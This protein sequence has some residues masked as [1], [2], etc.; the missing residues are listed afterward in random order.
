MRVKILCVAG[1]RPNFM[2]IAPLMRAFAKNPRFEAKLVHTGQHYDA[3]L[4][5]V[6]FEDLAI[7]RPDIELAV[8]S[9]SHAV[10]TAEIMLRFEPILEQEQPH[11]VLVVGDVNSTVACAL[12]TSKFRLRA[13]F[14]SSLGLRHRPIMIHVEA[15]LRSFDDDM[16]EEINR[17]LTDAA[18]D[19]LFV[20]EP[21]GLANLAREGVP[22]KRV[23]FVGNVMIDSLLAAKERALRSTILESLGLQAG[24]YGLVTLHRPSNVDDPK[25][26]SELLG[27]LGELA[28]KL[29][30]VFPVHPRTS[31]RLK[32]H[33]TPLDEGRWKLLE[34]VG[35]FDFLKLM[36]CASLVLTD[37][38]GIQ[39]ETTV[40][41][42]RCVTLRENTERPVTIDEGTNIL[43]GTSR[44]SILAAL[45][46]AQTPAAGRVPQYWD[47]QSAA[48]VERVLDP[49]F[50]GSESREGTLRT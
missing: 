20:S 18:S 19:L 30:L 45:Q 22:S 17:K 14:R 29:I 50:F 25:V 11:A 39:E 27:V 13:P 6:F 15:G 47:G 32:A 48:R 1:A 36:A 49:I 43:G 5:K 46:A 21:A 23:W 42:V 40:L 38:G 35:Y 8:G 37:S 26:L 7:P 2:K 24:Q 31:A 28:R 9:A 33:G 34:P 3:A 12:V 16:P 44:S 41:G 4:S 10:Q